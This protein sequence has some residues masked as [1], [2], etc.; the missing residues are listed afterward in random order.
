MLNVSL[1]EQPE[2]E[3]EVELFLEL[4]LERRVGA[5]ED[6]RQEDTIMD[7]HVLRHGNLE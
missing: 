4:L 1:V 7:G 3:A 5:G 6:Q 2:V